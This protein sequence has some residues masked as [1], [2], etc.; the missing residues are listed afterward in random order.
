[1][2][3]RSLVIDRFENDVAVLESEGGDSYTLSLGLLPEGAREGDWLRISLELDPDATGDA[4]AKVTALRA[5]I[6]IDDDGGDFAL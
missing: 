3:V 5:Q 2:T 6:L 1:M 4:R